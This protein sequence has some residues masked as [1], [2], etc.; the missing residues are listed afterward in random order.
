MI[1]ELR[2][3]RM[4]TR[5]EVAQ[6]LGVPEVALGPLYEPGRG[7][8][9]HVDAVVDRQLHRLAIV[10]D[11]I[12]DW[13]ARPRPPVPRVRVSPEFRRRREAQEH[14]AAEA[15]RRSE[16]EARHYRALAHLAESVV[17]SSDRGWP[18]PAW[19]VAARAV[20]AERARRG[21]T[22]PVSAVTAAALGL[23]ERPGP[24]R[25]HGKC[26]LCSQTSYGAVCTS[27][28]MDLR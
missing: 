17:A 2:C 28:R 4:P 22:R 19:L 24:S 10:L 5:A 21:I 15:A 13:P 27:C 3:W 25:N 16:V 1:D 9:G 12:A 6:R 11:P 8:A 14:A 20:D 7:L 23:D 26:V 18:R